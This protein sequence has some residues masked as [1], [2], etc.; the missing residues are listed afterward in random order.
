MRNV[1]YRQLVSLINTHRTWIQV[2]DSNCYKE[3][4]VDRRGDTYQCVCRT[5]VI[6]SYRPNDH[7][8]TGH[9]WYIPEYEL[10][11]ALAKLRRHDASVRKRSAKGGAWLNY[12]DVNVIV[13]SATHGLINLQLTEYTLF[14]IN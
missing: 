3:Y 13:R 2:K 9:L 7:Y 6:Q 8:K 1:I 11:K 4:V 14:D 10:D 12:S 5:L